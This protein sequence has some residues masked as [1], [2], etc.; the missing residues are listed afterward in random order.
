MANDEA[1]EIGPID[2]VVIGYRKDAPLTGEAGG[3]MLDLVERGVIRATR[4]S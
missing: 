4:C 1:L 2:I 3:V